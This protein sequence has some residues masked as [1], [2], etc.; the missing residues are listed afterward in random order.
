VD[1]P[2]GLSDVR[3]LAPGEGNQLAF[4]GIS[5]LI[6]STS[7]DSRGAFTLIES[8][9]SPHFAGF[10]PHL[11]RRMTEAFYIL[12]GAISFQIA[13]SSFT[14]TPGSFVLI[15]PGVVH[16]YSN[17]EAV[18]ARYLL[19]MSPGGFEKYLVELS[20]LIQSEPAWPPADPAA[21]EALAARYDATAP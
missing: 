21:L 20:N 9:I 15:P 11:H 6:K 17:P 14:A 2:Q 18:E 12:E 13:E 4:V 8:T 19:L 3:I 16:T 7:E 5:T 10:K 1:E